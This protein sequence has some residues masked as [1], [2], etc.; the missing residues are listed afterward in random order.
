[1]NEFYRTIGISKQA[2]HQY[3]QRQRLF[4]MKLGQ[5]I[6]EADDLRK[7]HP[8]CGV[9]KMYEILEP[10]FIGRDRF[11]EAFMQLGYRIKRKRNYK[12]TTIASKLFYPNLIKGLKINSPSSVWQS[13]ITY[14]KVG[15]RYYYAVFIIDVYTRKIVGYHVDDNMRATANVKALQMALKKHKAPRI[16]HSDRGSQ[17]TYKSYIELLTTNGSK[18]SMGLSAQDNAYVERFH[19]TLKEEYIRYWKPKSSQQLK[20]CIKKAVLNYNNIRTHRSLNKLTPIQFENKCHAMKT[21]K[22]PVLT[23]FEKES[24]VKPVNSI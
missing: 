7:D 10:D 1:M 18:V 4:D 12:K 21:D 8:G 17:Y 16:H 3:D 24:I 15:D 11:V 23:I 5:L 2:V 6:M 20:R 19:R 9:E 14:L 13:D 22:R